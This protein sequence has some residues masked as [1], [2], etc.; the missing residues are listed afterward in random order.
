MQPAPI[1]P[2]PTLWP[3]FV[4]YLVAFLLAF[5]A[6]AIYLI[7]PAVLRAGSNPE[8]IAN[9]AV[10]FAFSA[11]GLLGAALVSA[12][13]LALVTL[14][15]ARLLGGDIATR[16]H[17]RRT[18]ARPLGVAAA[19]VGLAGL[20]LA[21]GG[22]AQ[23]AGLGKAGVTESIALAL[24]SSNPTRIVLAVLAI[25]IAPAF[26]EEGFFRGLMQTRLR[27]RWTRWPAILVT[28]LAFGVFHVDPIQGSQA[29]IAGVFFGWVADRFGGIRSTIAAHAVNNAVFVV[30][31]SLEGPGDPATR[32]ATIGV[33][34]G[35]L[36]VCGAAIA[37][38]R[39]RYALRA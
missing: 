31:A 17:V 37:V 35:G 13:M 15:T 16:L 2:R 32:A 7:V 4:A 27:A 39:S 11:P 33:L 36:A 26:A 19:V 29:F 20:S 3:V 23:L 21:C 34:V 5:V 12:L 24:R 6:S 38:I 22:A 28:A 8:R 14:V 18:R 30:V 1:V 10:T 9:E 25:G